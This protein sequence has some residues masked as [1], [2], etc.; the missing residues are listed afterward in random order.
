MLLALITIAIPLTSCQKNQSAR[1]QTSGEIQLSVESVEAKSEEDIPVMQN[2]NGQAICVVFGYGFN[3]PDFYEDALNKLGAIYGLES[4]GGIIWPVIYPDDLRSRI[5]NLHDMA[6]EKQLKGIILLG[7]PENTHYMLAKLQD[8]WDNLPPYN[9]FSFFPQDDIL[10]EESTSSLI[11]EHTR[12]EDD[13]AEETELKVDA[14]TVDLLLRAVRYM[15]EL[16]GPLPLDS[17]LIAHVQHIA[18]NHKV[19]RYTDSE[20]GL[21]AI[22][23][24]VME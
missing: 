23:H 14:E 10:G 13:T 4:T 24:F 17:D 6:N 19:H 5:M 22:N 16:P 1:Q 15:L 21:Q 12:S 9:I 11:L 3:S 2:E 18:G 7:A 8:D 20:T